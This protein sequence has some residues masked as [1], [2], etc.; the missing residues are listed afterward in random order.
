[1][2]TIIQ[3]HNVMKRLQQFF[4]RSNTRQSQKEPF[5]YLQNYKVTTNT[6]HKI[7]SFVIISLHRDYRTLCTIYT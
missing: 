6:K 1:M 2:A 5:I 7:S 4:H 3:I